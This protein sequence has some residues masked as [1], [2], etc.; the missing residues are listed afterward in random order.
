MPSLIFTLP[1]LAGLALAADP[2]APRPNGPMPSAPALHL[3]DN[4]TVHP[5]PGVAPSVMDI[6]IS[7]GRIVELAPEI[8]PGAARVWKADGQHVYAG[9]IDAY[10]PV[11]APA[12][13]KSAPGN[14]WSSLVTPHR[15]ALA[16][17][18]LSAADAKSLR[19]L[20]FTAAA[21]APDAGIFR[22]WGAVVSTAEPYADPALG[23]PPVHRARTAQYLALETTGWGDGGYPDSKMGS[24]ALIRQTYLDAAWRAAQTAK[25]DANC[26]D[27]L[28][29]TALTIYDSTW[30]IEALLGDSIAREMGVE[31]LA[32]LGSGTEYKRL[33]ALAQAARLLIIPL[34][35]PETPD[36]W[37][38]GAADGVSLEDLSAWEL[39]PSNARFLADRGLQVSLTSS[40]LPR[41]QKFHDNLTKAIKNGLTADQ[42]LA[43]LTTN[44]AE[45]LGVSDT[46]GTIAEGKA[47]NLVITSAP[48]FQN[49]DQNK[50]DDK[51]K[52]DGASSDEADAA[53]PARPRRGG[54]AGRGASASD[55]AKI[56]AVWVDGRHHKITDPKDTRFDGTWTIAVLGTTHTMSMR[57]SGTEVTSIEEGD[58]SKAR[59]VDIKQDKISFVID[60][61]DDQG[62]GSYLVTGTLG[63]DGVIRGSGIAPDQS[64]FQWT[65]T[66]APAEPEAKP[67]PDAEKPLP[68]DDFPAGDQ[69]A[70]DAPADDTE[71]AEDAKPAKQP[72]APPAAPVGA[73]FA[74]YT[75]PEIP[76]A[77]ATLLVNATVW[78][79]S[80]KGI[81]E[82]GWVLIQDGK[83]AQVGQGGYPRIAAEVID[84]QGKH[85]T[86]GLIDAHSHTGLFRL[87]VNE[88]GQAVTAEVRIADSLDPGHI[89]F[90]RQLAGGLT[91]A[92]LLHGSANPSAASPRPSNSA[93][94]PSA[95]PTCSS[96]TPN[97]ASSSPSARMSSSPTG[98]TRTPPA[99]PQTRLGVETLIRDRF[100][101]AR[102]YAADRGQYDEAMKK[103]HSQ[104]KAT[105]E[106]IKEK[107]TD[108]TKV[109]ASYKV[110]I[111]NPEL[112]PPRD[113]ELEILAQI[114]AGERLVHSPLLPPGRDPHALPRRRGLRL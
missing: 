62:S 6:L 16:G 59:K 65:G 54:R 53:E 86:P 111:K 19:E 70:A 49:P 20:G 1:A 72:K 75:L 35:F 94:A 29:P 60:D 11:S 92:N 104:M 2:L 38:V 44:P 105:V 90:Y 31:R 21:I 47:A 46:L 79:Q 95:P 103:L 87:G 24:A 80:D 91:A 85:I 73:P 9:F 99:T 36:V 67:E 101:K 14:H 17:A 112:I 96:R 41:D 100:T 22:G 42:A 13:D 106:G 82:N 4:A 83:V 50:A 30:E 33:D 55:D 27:A 84:C 28:D 89:N 98:A 63:P 88:S 37:S 76:E 93:G 34:N 58:E 52:A 8:N 78:T 56:L 7:D 64:T 107:S 40:K 12:P 102:E 61:T 5:A 81:I 43:M 26:L 15:D 110:T 32:I 3:I 51:P 114:L 10:A 68:S 25:A 57:V 77:K 71:P 109:D 23:K 39:A 45:L 97:P 74:A 18:G 48:L 69:P 113:L 66:P 108:T